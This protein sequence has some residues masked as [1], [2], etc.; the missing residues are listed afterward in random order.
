VICY[1]SNC[2]GAGGIHLGA[3]NMKCKL[4]LSLQ[5]SFI[6]A[7]L[8]CVAGWSSADEQHE[9]K[10]TPDKEKNEVKEFAQIY[11][12]RFAK[13]KPLVGDMLPELIAW[14]A[15]GERFDIKQSHGAY[16]V[17]VFGCLT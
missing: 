16:R 5:Q 3:L 14:D 15:A 6:I 11:D 4:L 12:D 2:V 1:Y 9:T 8:A 7:C 13:Q 17:I 10:P